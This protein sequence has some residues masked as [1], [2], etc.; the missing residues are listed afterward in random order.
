MKKFVF[1]ATIAALSA[2][3]HADDSARKDHKTACR[4]KDLNGHYVMFQA[5]VNRPELN[6]NGRC[7]IDID[8]GVVSGTCEFG[9]NVSGNPN[10]AG[11]VYGHAVINKNCSADATISFDPVPNV[12]HIDSTFDLQFTPDKQSF[13]GRFNNNFGVEGISNGTRASASLP[14]SPAR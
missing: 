12:V 7:D 4:A 9:R 6:H 2:H 11:P 14:D 8:D 10:F 3:A 1:I 5:A 13:V